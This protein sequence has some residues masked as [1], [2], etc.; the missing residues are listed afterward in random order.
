MLARYSLGAICSDEKATLAGIAR[1][2]AHSVSTN[3]VASVA[4]SFATL[5]VFVSVP[6]VALS[7]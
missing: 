3:V 1:S 4:S 7:S 2:G 5:L 6:Q